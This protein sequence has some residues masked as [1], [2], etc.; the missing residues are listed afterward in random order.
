MLRGGECSKL[1]ISE[2]VARAAALFGSIA[3]E[4]GLIGRNLCIQRRVV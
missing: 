1:V 4:C 3:R 2:I